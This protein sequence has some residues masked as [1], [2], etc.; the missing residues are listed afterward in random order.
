MVGCPDEA[1]AL[2]AE[3]AEL[4]RR[5][6]DLGARLDLEVQ[7]DDPLIRIMPR[8]QQPMPPDRYS[9]KIPVTSLAVSPDGN[10]LTSSGYHEVLIWSLAD[11]ELSQRIPGIAERVYGIDYHPDG[12]VI[13]VAS[14]TP[15]RVGE[16][17]LFKLS[18]GEMVV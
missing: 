16:V 11:G 3:E 18:S 7:A 12:E 4:I 14:G 9:A 17:K 15:G 8:I 5:W 6:I 2:P 13:A 1:D 10:R